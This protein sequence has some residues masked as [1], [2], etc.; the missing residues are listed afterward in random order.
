[1]RPS[2]S[3]SSARIPS[4]VH[5]VGCPRMDLVARGA[6]RRTATTSRRSSSDGVGGTF[7]LE[8]PFVIV[9]QHPVTTEYGD[10]ERQIAATLEAVQQLGL[11]AIVLWPN[12]DAGSEDIA[13]RHPQVP[14]ARGRRAPALLQEP[15]DVRLHEADERTAVLVGNL[16]LGDP[17]GRVHRHARGEHRLAP[18]RARSAAR[19]SID[20]GYDAGEIA[21]AIARAGRA[22]P[23]R[24]GADLRRRARGRA[25]RRHP[26]RAATDLAPEAH[27]V[28]TWAGRRR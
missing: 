24:A 9:S 18:D 23:L 20:V 21:E 26:R 10:G 12:A 28:L 7:D 5:V 22:R 14:R 25:H 3:S 15:A 16:E 2:G 4:T 6:A 1:M 11:P 13:A 8:Q 19:T 17:R 27:D